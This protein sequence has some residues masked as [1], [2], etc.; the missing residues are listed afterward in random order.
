MEKNSKVYIAGHLG[1]VGGAIKQTLQTN[2]YENIIVRSRKELDLTRQNDVEIFF[3]NEKPEYVIIAAAKVGGIK[4]NMEYPAEFLYINLL[5][6]SN[7]IHA[8]YKNGV[9]KLLFLGSS[10]IYPKGCPQPMKEEYLLDG[11]LEPTNESYAIA[12]IAGMKMCEKYYE[13]YGINFTSLMPT[14][15]FGPNDNFDLN[16]SH[17]LPAL[18]RKFHEAKIH[19]QPE[20]EVWGTGNSR[21]EFLYVDDLADAVLYFMNNYD[22]K[23]FFSIRVFKRFIC[24]LYTIS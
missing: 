17:V 7:I 3:A 22:E 23:Q 10:C 15:I 18:L 19:N 1:L 24:F 11:K 4:A 14:N 2:G 8:A 5:I 6:Q 13:Q 16:T 9:K 21:R 12:K 20:V